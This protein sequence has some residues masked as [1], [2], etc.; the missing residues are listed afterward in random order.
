M[1]IRA[2]QLRIDTQWLPARAGHEHAALQWQ[3]ARAGHGS[4]EAHTTDA[5]AGDIYRRNLGSSC[6]PV[7]GSRILSERILTL[8]CA[9]CSVVI[10]QGGEKVSHGICDSCLARELAA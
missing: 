3:L 5:S 4:P 9:W 7:A 2:G 6:D 1:K 10:R 8:S